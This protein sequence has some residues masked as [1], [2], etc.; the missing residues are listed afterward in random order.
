[1]T[2]VDPAT[3]GGAGRQATAPSEEASNVGG[4][5]DGRTDNEPTGWRATIVSENFTFIS[6]VAVTTFV[7]LRAY[8]AARFS[9]TTASALIT[10][11]PLSV[12]FGTI[13]S[14]AYAV[15]PL[16]CIVGAAWFLAS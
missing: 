10:T 5:D 13:T 12:L 4:G 11:A 14:Y 16:L 15:L 3:P 2:R 9:L 8:G 6:A 7:T 1:M